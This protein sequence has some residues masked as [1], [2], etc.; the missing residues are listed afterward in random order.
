MNPSPLIILIPFA[1]ALGM[2]IA[3]MAAGA[4]PGGAWWLAS[5]LHRRHANRSTAGGRRA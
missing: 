2:L 4:L 1:K 5:R 3:C